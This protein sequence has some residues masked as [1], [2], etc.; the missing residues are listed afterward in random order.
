M[1]SKKEIAWD[2]SEIY[3]GYNDPKIFEMIDLFKKQTDDFVDEYRGKIHTLEFTAQ[4]LFDLFKRQEKFFADLAELSMYANRLFDANMTI[5]E[6]ETLK[7]N[8]EDFETDA[9]KKLTFFELEIGKLV[10]DRKELMDD[11]ILQDYKHYLEKI[12]REVPHQ[13]SEV[14]EQIILEKDQYGVKAWRP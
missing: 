14:E 12:R 3:A 6:V 9:L 4:N 11:I 8:I 13:L 10:Y 2:L 1:A 5:P 7:N